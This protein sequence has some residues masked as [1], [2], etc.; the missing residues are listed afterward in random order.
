MSAVKKILISNNEVTMADIRENKWEWFHYDNPEFQVQFRHNFIPAGIKILDISI[1]W[2]DDVEFIYVLKGATHYELENQWIK[3]NAGEGIFVNSRQ[4]HL[5]HADEKED[6]EL[7]CLIFH[8]VILCSTNHITENYVK[9]LIENKDIP[10]LKLDGMEKWQ[11]HILDNI[12]KMESFL[13]G[14][15]GHIK[16]INL[17]FDIWDT[18]FQHLVTRESEK[19]INKD[20]SCMKNMVAYIQKNYRS[21]VTLSEICEAGNVGKSKCNVLFDKYMNMSPIEY[22]KN[23]RIEQGAKLL[24][25][26]DMSVTDIAYEVGFT[27]SSYF[28]KAFSKKIG[29]TPLKYRSIGRGMSSYYELRESKGIQTDN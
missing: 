19:E 29:I 11:H 21:K 10:Y 17:I 1:H 13:D 28:S 18:L 12:E 22:V 24:T 2:H 8:P 5:I 25:L 20:L 23:L 27:D 6:C 14:D 9:P 7:L 4:L 15:R 26:S 3:M 16:V